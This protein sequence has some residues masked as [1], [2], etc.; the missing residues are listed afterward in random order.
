MVDHGG[1]A[2][3]PPS[4]YLI[5]T[6]EQARKALRAAMIN[7]ELTSRRRLDAA[8]LSTALQADP[9]AVRDALVDLEAEGMLVTDQHGGLVLRLPSPADTADLNELRSAVEEL[10]VRRF[11]TRASAAQ[12]RALRLASEQFA[13]LAAEHAPLSEL[14]DAKDW[15]FMLLLRGAGNTSAISLL[16]RERGRIRLL[17]AAA[18]RN[19]IGVA[20]AAEQ[21]AAMVG[22]IEAR[23]ADAAVRACQRHLDTSTSVGLTELAA[24]GLLGS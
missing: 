3:G 1:A 12:I 16:V 18:L 2:D 20:A 21:L 14:T 17:N 15:F 8:E 6:P 24:V 5:S 23:D 11:T 19:P 13:R 7:F 10:T 22:A 9:R 4:R